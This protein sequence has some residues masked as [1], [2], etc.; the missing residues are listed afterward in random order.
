[1]PTNRYQIA[2][3]NFRGFLLTKKKVQSL[4]IITFW[5]SVVPLVGM[6]Y[7]MCNTLK[8]RKKEVL[9]GFEIT[10]EDIDAHIKASEKVQDLENIINEV[11]NAK[12]IDEQTKS[13]IIVS[14]GK[15]LIKYSETDSQEV[16]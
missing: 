11:E 6:I 9:E 2:S 13:R 14:V 12:G 5:L 7:E 15:E 16:T 4:V 8:Q 3:E 10:K 1:M